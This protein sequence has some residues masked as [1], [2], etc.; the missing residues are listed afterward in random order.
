MKDA[1]GAT[2]TAT[3][4]L[5]VNPINDSPAITVPATIAATEDTKLTFSGA[6]AITIDDPDSA[7]ITTT[8]TVTNGKLTLA[9]GSGVTITGSGTGTLQL[10][11]SSANITAALAAMTYDAPADYNGPAT[12]TVSS[13]DGIGTNSSSI[14]LTVAPVVDVTPD[15]VTTNEDNAIT[16][17]VLH[18]T[19]APPPTRSR[20]A[21]RR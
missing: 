11:G 9:S 16:F 17:D 3:V 10:V 1:D 13:T 4:T 7:S 20:A 12:L 15:A 14:A 8:I 5:N 6:N 18:G 19:N 2:T 21:R